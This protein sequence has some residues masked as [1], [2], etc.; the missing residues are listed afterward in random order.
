M[1]YSKHLIIFFN[2]QIPDTIS[3]LY[4]DRTKLEYLARRLIEKLELPKYALSGDNLIK[5]AL[6]LL[7]ARENIPVIICGDAGC[8]KSS[9]ITYLARNVYEI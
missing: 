6:I 7:K 9:L 1:D 4:R 3:A 8:G 5:M 2:S